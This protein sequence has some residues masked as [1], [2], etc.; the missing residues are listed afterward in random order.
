MATH[1]DKNSNVI[2]LHSEWIGK[3]HLRVR[4]RRVGKSATIMVDVT[5]FGERTSK[6]RAA[7]VAGSTA[8]SA[9]MAGT[10]VVIFDHE[11]PRVLKR[12]DA[13]GNVIESKTRVRTT[14]FAFG[15]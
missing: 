4:T 5:E 13:N 11:T 2:G 7:S 9:G 6:R 15:V 14:T 10:G 8:K 1:S 12:L 3:S